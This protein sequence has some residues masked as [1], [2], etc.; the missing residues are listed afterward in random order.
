MIKFLFK[1]KLQFMLRELFLTNQMFFEVTC[2]M[3]CAI[4]HQFKKREKQSWRNF[5]FSKVSGLGLQL[6]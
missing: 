4:W 1:P 5:N 3:L 2:E 6:Y